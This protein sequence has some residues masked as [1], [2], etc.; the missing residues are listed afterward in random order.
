[1]HQMISLI[2]G[3]KIF[4]CGVSKEQHILLASRYKVALTELFGVI[5]EKNC[6][7]IRVISINIF[8]LRTNMAACKHRQIFSFLCSRKSI[9]LLTGVTLSP[10][11]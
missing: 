10:L 4:W 6:M 8:K 1:M 7:V 9:H 5:T 3:L 11:K 2:T